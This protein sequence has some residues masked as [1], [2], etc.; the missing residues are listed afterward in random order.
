MKQGSQVASNGQ[1]VVTP[2][3]TDTRAGRSRSGITRQGWDFTPGLDN[4][5]LPPNLQYYPLQTGSKIQIRMGFSNNPD[6]L[7]PVFSGKVTQIEEGEIMTI[8]AQ[9]FGVELMDPAPDDISTN[10][11]SFSFIGQALES[12]VVGV[13][14]MVVGSS[15]APAPGQGLELIRGALG[16]GPA[17]GG[18]AIM[19]DTGNTTSVIQ[20]M[21]RCSTATHFGHWQVGVPVEETLKGYGYAKITADLVDWFTQTFTR[22]KT[23]TIN[24]S[25]VSAM[26]RNGYDR[27]G[28]NIFISFLAASD[29]TVNQT[30]LMRDF[31]MEAP[32]NLAP[33]SYYV[34]KD[35]AITPWRI[36]QD[37]RRRYPEYICAVKPYGF[38]Y[39][40]DATLVFA[41]PN[42]FYLG[43]MPTYNEAEIGTLSAADISP[44]LS[45]WNLN[46]GTFQSFWDRYK[47][48]DW[49]G[50]AYRA[51]N[52][53]PST[54]R[55]Y[56]SEQS[57]M[58]ALALSI[59]N[60]SNPT[61][62]F[63]T[64][65]NAC[66]A[67]I[68][69]RQTQLTGFINFSGGQVFI[70][71]PLTTGTWK[72]EAKNLQAEMVRFLAAPAVA[73]QALRSKSDGLSTEP[74]PSDRMQPVRKWHLVTYYNIIHNGIQLNGDI[75]NA[76]RVD[77]NT[78]PANDCMSAFS[79][80]LRVLDCDSLII[81]PVNNVRR[82][83]LYRPY[84]Q[85][86]LKDELGKMYRGELV[87]SAVPEID[88]FDIILLV[89]PENGMMGPIEVDTVIQS[90]DPEMGHI[91][92][93]KPKAV[94][95]V[96]EAMTAG[97]G[98]AISAFFSNC[99]DETKSA[100]KSLINA[101]ASAQVTI[102]TGV[103]AAAAGGALALNTVAGVTSAAAGAAGVTLT[104]AAGPAV[105]ALAVALL[106]VGLVWMVNK[107]QDLNPVML[108]PLSRYGIPWIGGVDGWRM[109]DLHSWL[110]SEWR[111]FNTYELQPTLKGARDLYG[112][113]SDF[114]IMPSR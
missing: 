15:G 37:V 86:F 105:A 8:V 59:T 60:G 65:M 75:N 78:V 83:N 64:V 1:A 109:A 44:F 43:R 88:P 112:I 18:Y 36:I 5:L 108:A 53:N 32:F 91:T 51:I 55:G 30:H 28:E 57:A 68:Q 34:P 19:G 2:I 85:S 104:V 49:P 41:N 47:G 24:Y 80:H 52:G 94:V 3:G 7:Y 63:T 14:Q 66:I 35:A 101:P 113:G 103:A 89:D 70:N 17:Y 42:D 79:A 48:Y 61:G 26:L 71:T 58:N 67:A 29:G 39:G 62:A 13:K 46:K 33:A 92:I 21:L 99:V 93:V 110:A 11:Y 45:W 22:Q 6:D 98:V 100:V 20:A 84:A 77:E 82:P 69:A 38:P 23:A 90:F 9:G 50:I 56:Y 72:A 106:G 73:M 74:R 114:N 95:L 102:G 10:G 111:T 87:L 25:G 12:V 27:S 107:R 54:A 4:S 97:L 16:R 76:V 81:D 40:C 31:Q 96:N